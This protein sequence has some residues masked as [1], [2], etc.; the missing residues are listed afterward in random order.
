MKILIIC[1][2]ID[3]YLKKQV[4]ALKLASRQVDILDLVEYKMYFD[5]GKKIHIRPKSKFKI[6]EHF[7]VSDEIN[8]YYRR[9]E[10][11]NYLDRYD[12][13]NLYK[14]SQYAVEIKDQI[15]KISLK[16]TIT[17]N[18]LLP[19]KSTKLQ[20]LYSQS[21]AF[22]FGNEKLKKTFN[23]IYGFEENSFTLY[24]PIK[25][26]EIYNQI[27][28]SVLEKFIKYLSVSK[29]KKNIF[30]HFTGSKTLQKEL[31]IS[32]ANL[33]IEVKKASTFFLYLDN[34]DK[35]ISDEI[36]IMLKNIKLDY[37]IIKN[38]ATL[39]QLAMLLKVSSASVFIDHSPFNDILFTSIYAMNHPF[40]FK[41]KNI[42]PIYKKEKIF[43]DNFSE[44]YSFFEK[45][46]IKADL[47]KEIYKI[48]KQKIY[49]LFSYKSF[50]ERFIEATLR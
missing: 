26:I 43:L 5:N 21:K 37:V 18:D 20:E 30:C 39:E 2:S 4:E 27:D 13:V 23:S 3:S 44:F 24:E 36:L 19:R 49:T 45:D 10:L 34:H 47:Y 35:S 15:K 14:C 12:I 40:L 46:D 8:E 48:N 11:F 29:D 9:R 25:L 6:L 16:Y 33:P 42:D 28:S 32:L 7:F 1:T 17:L 50:E 41:P 38:D 31:I 22:F